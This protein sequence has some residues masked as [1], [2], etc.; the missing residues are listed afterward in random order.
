MIVTATATVVVLS[1]I[2][3]RLIDHTQYK[4]VW[5]GMWWAIQTVTTVGYWRRTT[6]EGKRQDPRVFR[7]TLEGIAFLAIVV[8]AAITSSF[9]ARAEKERGLTEADADQNHAEHLDTRLDELSTRLDEL[10][11]RLDG[12]EVMLRS[13]GG[14][15]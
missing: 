4:N 6:Y 11:T 3:M 12:I 9:I 10:S 13:L 15:G 2:A 5:V 7:G 8:T 14:R 1:G